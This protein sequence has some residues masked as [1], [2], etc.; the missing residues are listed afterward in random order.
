[1]K[2]TGEQGMK[3]V[4]CACVP[5]VSLLEARE[6]RRFLEIVDFIFISF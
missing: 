1:L 4:Q 6:A 2:P 5:E 3:E